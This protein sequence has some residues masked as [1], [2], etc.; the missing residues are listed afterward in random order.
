MASAP[1]K[2][3]LG[4]IGCGGIARGRHLTGLALLKKAGLENFRVTA[5]CDTSAETMTAILK[6]D[7]PPI[8][9][10]AAQV[11]LIVRHCLEKEPRARYQSARDLAFQLQLVRH[12]SSPSATTATSRGAWPT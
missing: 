9:E 8:P 12:P 4:I 10:A 11:E 1:D 7:P 6:H 3:R 2:I 5:L